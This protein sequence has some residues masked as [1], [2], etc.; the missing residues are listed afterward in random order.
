VGLYGENRLN[1]IVLLIDRGSVTVVDNP[2]QVDL[3]LS[4]L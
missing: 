1:G 4:Q 2:N 3:K